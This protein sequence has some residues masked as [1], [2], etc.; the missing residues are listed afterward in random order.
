[1]D[2]MGE[3]V[4]WSWGAG[5]MGGFNA[6][7]RRRFGYHWYGNWNKSRKAQGGG[8][9]WQIEPV[10]NCCSRPHNALVCTVQSG[11]CQLVT[12]GWVIVWLAAR[13]VRPRS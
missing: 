5:V 6:F 13:S 7:V 8:I 3:V 2:G 4:G 12:V 1:M 9:V 10:V 11:S